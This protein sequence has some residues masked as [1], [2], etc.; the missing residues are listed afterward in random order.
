MP[1]RKGVENAIA[2]YPRS[3]MTPDPTDS[4][5]AAPPGKR[6][7]ALDRLGAANR[8]LRVALK[9]AADARAAEVVT[10]KAS[11]VGPRAGPRLAGGW[12]NGRGG[13]RPLQFFGPTT[14]A[15]PARAGVPGG[16]LRGVLRDDPSR[17]N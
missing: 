1:R 11:R 6:P 15:R 4:L 12:G 17:P 9:L 3:R 14:G 10:A 13:E 8:Q 2:V 16:G 5:F 7:A